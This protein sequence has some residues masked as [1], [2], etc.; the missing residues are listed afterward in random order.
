MICPE[1]Q[2][3][4]GDFRDRSRCDRCNRKIIK[5]DGHKKVLYRILELFRF[6]KHKYEMVNS[7]NIEFKPHGTFT[8]A[9]YM[10]KKGKCRAREWSVGGFLDQIENWEREHGLI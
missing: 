4:P 9:L 3:L 8:L 7:A 5:K 10:C 2:G 6:H 1:C